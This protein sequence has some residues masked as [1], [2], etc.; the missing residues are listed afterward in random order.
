MDIDTSHPEGF[1]RVPIPEQD[2]ATQLLTAIKHDEHIQESHRTLDAYLSEHCVDAAFRELIL[3]VIEDLPDDP[4]A[5]M[6]LRLVN[7]MQKRDSPL[8]VSLPHRLD[9]SRRIDLESPQT[10]VLVLLRTHPHLSNLD[11]SIIQAIRTRMVYERRSAGEVIYEA[12]STLPGIN[13]VLAGKVAMRRTDRP[14]ESVIYRQGQFF[15]EVFCLPAAQPYTSNARYIADGDVGLAI[16]PRDIYIT[17]VF[18]QRRNALTG[19]SI[20]NHIAARFKSLSGDEA[21]FLASLGEL[22]VFARGECITQKGH[23]A[24]SLYV[25]VRGES[26]GIHVGDIIGAPS[27]LIGREET[28]TL[29]CETATECMAISLDDIKARPVLFKKLAKDLYS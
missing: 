20:K 6:A 25:V 26:T 7:I 28:A 3:A 18:N 21:S 2:L 12:G 14:G 22:A 16:L 13:F 4:Y 17:W 19:K 9:I 23:L 5:A 11:E 1:R 15:G 10:Q 27:V 29:E 8:C 24:S